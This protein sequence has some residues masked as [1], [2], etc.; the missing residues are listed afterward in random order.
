MAYLP[1]QEEDQQGQQ[2]GVG[3]Q[4]QTAPAR[5]IQH[6]GGGQSATLGSGQNIERAQTDSPTG[7]T[8]INRYLDQ[9]KQ[10][11]QQMADKVNQNVLDTA[12]QAS[13][14]ITGAGEVFNKQAEQQRV[15]YDPS[16]FV[17]NKQVT[18][19]EIRWRL[20][21]IKSR[22]TTTPQAAPQVTD[23]DIKWALNDITIRHGGMTDAAA[24]ETYN[25]AKQK[26]V[27]A[28]R[29]EQ[30]VPGTK[31]WLQQQG[32]TLNA[33]VST[34]QV[35]DNDIKWA[36]NDLTQRYGGGIAAENQIYN[37]AKEHGVSA[38]RLEQFLPGTQNWLQQQ[39]KTL[40]GAPTTATSLFSQVN[41]IANDQSRMQEFLRQ[42]DAEYRGL[43][44]IEED[45]D[46]FNKMR[47]SLDNV[48]NVTNMVRSDERGQLVAQLMNPDSRTTAG[49]RS[50][51]NMMFADKA[52]QEQLYNT[53]RQVDDMDLQG[54]YD[55]VVTG[56]RRL[57]DDI[58]ST[59]QATREQ[60]GKDLGTADTTFKSGL[61][62]RVANLQ[63]NAPALYQGIVDAIGNRGMLTDEQINTIGIDRDTAHR[64]WTSS[65]GYDL[66]DNYDVPVYNPL[67]SH[68]INDDLVSSLTSLKTNPIN[69]ND[70]LEYTDPTIAY[71][72]NTVASQDDLARQQALSLLMGTNLD[73]IND[74][75][76][77]GTAPTSAMINPE[78]IV[79]LI[80]AYNTAINPVQDA[81]SSFYNGFI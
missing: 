19:D 52:K 18:D 40:D 24:N 77:V 51:D 73:Y 2:Q 38:D 15:N 35:S 36:I 81:L 25:L 78:D 71:N 47:T 14:T 8:N 65:L 59:N 12:S 72:R 56:S 44:S 3:Q 17:N 33:P 67:L 64:L 63:E 5:S 62:S 34:P 37:A 11:G 53:I 30:F 39:G 69:Y 27:T 46:T 70:Y 1:N 20:N 45:Y 43:N 80:N 31:T 28:D 23:D 21:D 66:F 76:L 54:L 9:N 74:P 7:F 68:T 58:R 32:K 26:G 60:I 75:T 29:L 48:R 42:R 10:Q 55:N 13:S 6:L 50:L 49:M 61:D 41:Q 79:N 57:V 22:H 16:Q 4:G